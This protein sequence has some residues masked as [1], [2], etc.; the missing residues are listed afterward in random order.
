[1]DQSLLFVRGFLVAHDSCK[2]QTRAQAKGSDRVD[3][4]NS[5]MGIL[6]PVCPFYFSSVALRIGEIFLIAWERFLYFPFLAAHEL[7]SLKKEVLFLLCQTITS[8]PTLQKFQFTQ[9]PTF[10][11]LGTCLLLS[12]FKTFPQISP[13][14]SH[15]LNIPVASFSAPG[16]AVSYLH[17]PGEGSK[18]SCQFSHRIN[19]CWVPN[20][21]LFQAPL[22]GLSWS[23]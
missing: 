13:S 6:R 1:M 12:K 8:L 5:S 2:T 22:V 15:L 18:L 9:N 7:F 3:D 16:D 14:S 20:M 11:R 10:L 17:V 23:R 19:I 21:C 4:G